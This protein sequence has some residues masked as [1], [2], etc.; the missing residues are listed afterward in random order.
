MVLERIDTPEARQL[1]E[2][3]S[4]AVEGTLLTEESRAARQRMKP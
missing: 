1:L 4:K 2:K 3:L